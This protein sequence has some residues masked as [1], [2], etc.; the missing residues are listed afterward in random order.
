[1]KSLKDIYVNESYKSLYESNQVLVNSLFDTD[2]YVNRLKL[3]N[4]LYEAEIITASR[5]DAYVECTNCP[6]GAYRGTL[7]LKINPFKLKEFMIN[8]IRLK[9]ILFLEQC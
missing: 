7:Q 1:M 2:D 5:E 3:F 6:P 4:H 8:C 9:Q